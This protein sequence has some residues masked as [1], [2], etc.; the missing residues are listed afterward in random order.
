MNQYPEI[1]RVLTENSLI[2]EI[3]YEVRQIL[4]GI[5]VKDQE[6]A[7]RSEERRV[8]KEC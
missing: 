6:R 7:D 1:E 8:G 2:D 5:V 3:I 4:K